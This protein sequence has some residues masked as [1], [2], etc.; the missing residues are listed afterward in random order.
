MFEQVTDAVTRSI[1]TAYTRDLATTILF[2]IIIGAV[3]AAVYVGLRRR[4]FDRGSRILFDDLLLAVNP[5]TGKKELDP[6]R[7]MLMGGF[8]IAALILI[9]VF[10]RG[11]PVAEGLTTMYGLFLAAIVAPAV[12]VVLKTKVILPGGKP[13]EPDGG[14]GK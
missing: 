13:V 3:A 11:L 5:L 1:E 12:S 4:N 14:H 9:Y 10:A 2:G 6:A 7:C 8:L